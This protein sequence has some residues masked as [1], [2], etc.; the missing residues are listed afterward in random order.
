EPDGLVWVSRNGTD[1]ARIGVQDA[2]LNLELLQFLDDPSADQAA[3]IAEMERS[4]PPLSVAPAGGAG[5]R[6]L[7]AVA[8]LGDGFIAVGSMYDR[9]NADPIVVVSKETEKGLQLGGEEPVVKGPGLQRYND[10]CVATDGKALA[11][12]DH[13]PTRAHDGIAGDREQVGQW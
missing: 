10:V 1:W 6:S 3:A 8:P 4:A 11:V 7:G 9:G 2:R 5:T 12:G 13:R